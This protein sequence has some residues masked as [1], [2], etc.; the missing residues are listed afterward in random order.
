MRGRFRE[1]RDGRAID[2]EADATMANRMKRPPT[3]VFSGFLAGGVLLAA[4]GAAS[5]H[6]SF[7]AF[8]IQHPLELRGT[9]QEF[10]FTSPHTYIVL[11]VKAEDGGTET[12]SLEGASPSTLVREGW[13]SRTL[14]SGDEI[15]LTI[16][17]LRSGAPGGAWTAQKTNYPDGR[18]VVCCAV[19]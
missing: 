19:E 15:K 17:P 6:H 2:V 12:W 16:D 8:D 7:A 18:P 11:Q 10:R 3:G 13:S 5:A 1:R 9:V 14:S 4:G